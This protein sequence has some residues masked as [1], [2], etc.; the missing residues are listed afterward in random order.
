MADL[1]I[2]SL[3][4][5]LALAMSTALAAQGGAGCDVLA[6]DSESFSLDGSNNNNLIHFV[7]PTIK[8]CNLKI[9]ADDAFS[10]G[11]EFEVHSEWRFTGHVRIT[12]EGKFMEADSAVF[13]FDKNQLS[14]AEL[15]GAPASFVASR[16]EPG[17]EPVRGSANKIYFDYVAQTLRMSEG[18]VITK[19]RLRAQGCN[20]IY[21]FKSEYMGS[22]DVDC[23][24]EGFKIRVVNAQPQANATPPA[25]P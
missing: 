7:R 17:K 4:F 22:G 14:R 13:V 21:D 1:A 15:V 16:T 24:A 8:Q 23:G 19:D 6:V 10:T 18:V 9:E 11:V 3:I 5:V 12:A 20:V 2:R 25:P